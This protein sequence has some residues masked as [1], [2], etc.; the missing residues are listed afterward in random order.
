MRNQ[1]LQCLSLLRY[2]WQHVIPLEFSVFTMSNKCLCAI[3]KTGSVTSTFV[4]IA[5]TGKIIIMKK[6]R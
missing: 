2:F 4:N 3:K 1:Q 5:L 6:V